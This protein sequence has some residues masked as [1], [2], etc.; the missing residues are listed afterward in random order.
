M[1]I[2]GNSIVDVN[3]KIIRA[4][5]SSISE[6]LW[7]W[8]WDASGT[9]CSFKALYGHLC[10]R[11]GIFNFEVIFLRRK[12]LDYWLINW[13]NFRE[14]LNAMLLYLMANIK[15][16]QEA[17]RTWMRLLY[18]QCYQYAIPPAIAPSL[19]SVLYFFSPGDI[20]GY[21]SA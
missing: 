2:W 6:V 13:L 11:V 18:C 16:Q 14:H 21:L 15:K 9:R 19:S 5:F 1:L 17:S 3:I 8:S 4:I 20:L 12:F 10:R 7:A